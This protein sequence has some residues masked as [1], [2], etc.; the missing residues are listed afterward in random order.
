MLIKARGPEVDTIP[1]VR[2]CKR[3]DALLARLEQ[4]ADVSTAANMAKAVEASRAEAEALTWP[5][6]NELW[7][8]ARPGARRRHRSTVCAA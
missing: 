4:A 6:S 2:L 3:Y 7:R 1:S 5:S 8:R